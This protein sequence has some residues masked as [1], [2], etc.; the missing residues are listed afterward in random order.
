MSDLLIL[1]KCDGFQ[2]SLHS[3]SLEDLTSALCRC[4]VTHHSGNRLPSKDV[5]RYQLSQ[6][7]DTNLLRSH[8]IDEHGGDGVYEWQ[9][10]RNEESPYWQT[11]VKHL[12]G[13]DSYGE[14]EDEQERKP[15]IGDFGVMSHKFHVNVIGFRLDIQYGTVNPRAVIQRSM[16]K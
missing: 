16:H 1:H 12:D 5:S 7:V 15:P 11:R 10:D 3:V 8:G 6:Q 2:D 9:Y 13:D 4:S 14:T